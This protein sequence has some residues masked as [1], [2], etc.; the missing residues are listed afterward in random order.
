MA[1]WVGEGAKPFSMQHDTEIGAG[2]FFPCIFPGPKSSASFD[3]RV[4]F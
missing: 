4:V 3:E 2:G 1:S